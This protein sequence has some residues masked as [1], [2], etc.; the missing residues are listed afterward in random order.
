MSEKLNEVNIIQSIKKS[1]ELVKDGEIKVL[2]VY[3]I[4]NTESY[5]A[6]VE[7]DPKTFNT[8]MQDGKVIIGLNNCKVTEYLNVIRCYKCCGYMHKSNVCRNKRA[9]LRCGGEH[10][11]REC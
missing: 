10:E 2:H 4:K 1:N 6:I 5:G 7:V 8:L 9:C 3:D 11:V